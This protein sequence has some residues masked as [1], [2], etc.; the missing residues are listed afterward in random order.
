M[1]R[2]SPDYRFDRLRGAGLGG[3]KRKMI[4]GPHGLNAAMRSR[5][6]AVLS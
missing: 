5:R 2:A 3:K 4:T 6:S 1:R